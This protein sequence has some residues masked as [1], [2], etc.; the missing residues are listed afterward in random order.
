M[1]QILATPQIA[2]TPAVTRAGVEALRR[3][4]QGPHTETDV[5]FQI[6]VAMRLAQLAEEAETLEGG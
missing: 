2:A 1:T 5:V 3:V 6:F 4:F